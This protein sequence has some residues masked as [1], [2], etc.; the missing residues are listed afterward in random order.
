MFHRR[1]AVGIIAMATIAFASHAG[2]FVV[3]KVG[4][5]ADCPYST[6]QDAVDAAAAN[7]GTDYVWIAMNA[8][9]T[10]QQV[11]ITDQD[12][13]VEGGFTDCDDID[14]DTAVT[15][16]SGAGNAGGAVFTVRGTSNVYFGN[17]SITGASRD[18]DAS[19]G[20][21]DFDGVG[22]LILQQTA[23]TNNSAGYGAG[24]NVKGDGGHVDVTLAHDTLF[25]TNTAGTSG[26]GI[27][28]EGDAR[29]FALQPNTL[30][31]FNHAP[32][33]YGG[34]IEVLGPAQAD[35]GSPGYNTGAVIQFNDAQ[36]GGG[37]AALAPDENQ[38]VLVRLFTMDA[39]NP[40]QI[41]NNS[42][43]ATGGGIYL[44]PIMTTTLGHGS[45]T[46]CASEFRIDDNVAQEGSAIYADEDSF[47]GQY[48]GSDVLL[49]RAVIAGD[50]C[51][52]PEP[53]GNLGAVSCADG[54]SC[55]TFDANVTADASA[56]PTD[57]AAVL[58]Q[59]NG[60][61]EGTRFRAT[62]NA[63]AHVLREL[64]DG[65]GAIATMSDCL[66]AGNVLTQ[67]VLTVTDGSLAALTVTSC[68]IADNQIGAPYVMLV[69]DFTE[70]S[71]SIVAQPDRATIDA[72]GDAP[73]VSYVLS[74]DT[75]T[76]GSG[77]G[78]I[79]GTP[80]FV[81]AANADYHLVDVSAGVDFAPAAD[82]LDLDGHP[83][84]VDLNCVA[85]GAGALDLGAYETQVC[86]PRV[87]EIF[88]AGFEFFIP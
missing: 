33:G 16:V 48:W 26:G 13:I 53:I 14:V 42:A 28:V 24:M 35:I 36:Y 62:R 86:G 56:N 70:L 29:L 64:G 60:Y 3:Y 40:V 38:N 80:T 75:S 85:N 25:L 78:V 57:G 17:L 39:A 87:D 83:R 55:N 65:S 51:S 18:G 43:S 23:V 27:R 6:I 1:F 30:I 10:G 82:D 37:I 73:A 76:L 44:K 45:S 66:L 21:I 49:N 69:G 52:E 11:T 5:D 7:P 15:T 61:F 59:T 46:L 9:Y 22:S 34:G 2:A 71:N 20:G 68:T 84:T 81:D 67:E 19:G 41:A 79:E 32:N 77:P 72:P 88:D 50:T 74:N 54:I 47:V 4:G 12:V 63:G 8:I 31:G 58:M